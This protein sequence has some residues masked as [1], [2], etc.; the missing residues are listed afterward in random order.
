[1]STRALWSIPFEELLEAH[2]P[3]LRYAWA[4]A[5][6]AIAVALPIQWAQPSSLAT[7][8]VLAV[9]VLAVLPSWLWLTGRAVGLPIVPI[10]ALGELIIFAYP[11]WINSEAISYYSGEEILGACLAEIAFLGTMIIAWLAAQ[12]LP[13]RSTRI[14]ALR[15][16][17]FA[18]SGRQSTLFLTL[19]SSACFF[20]VAVA[21]GWA[22]DYFF[23]YVPNGV[24]TAFRPAATIAG[25]LGI[26]FLSMAHGRRQLSIPQRVIYLSIFLLYLAALGTSILLSAL[27]IQVLAWLAGYTLG[28]GRIPWVMVLVLPM[29]LNLLHVGKWEMRREHWDQFGGDADVIAPTEYPAFYADW[30][31]SGWEAI[32]KEEE[33]AEPEDSTSILDRASLVQMYLLAQNKAPADVPFLE[34]ETYAVIPKLMIPRI[35]WPDKPRTHLAQVILNVHFGRQTLEDTA[36]TY[37]AWGMLAESW[38]NFGIF[39]PPV[40]GLVLGGFLGWVAKLGYRVPMGSM[41]FLLSAVV[42]L[43]SINATQQVMSIWITT[44]FQALIPVIGACVLTMSPV[45]RPTP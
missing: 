8:G 16:D 20:S 38:S 37:I 10:V 42:L 34:G 29:V 35:L 36:R 45:A 2:R 11:V 17:G 28:R 22:W 3:M 27:A 23:Q 32:S 7:V 13:D 33:L 12:S 4:F 41:R 15:L 6:A 24:Y 26:F 19:L 14:L 25:L 30:F 1:M 18:D 21:A 39:G 44:L 40:L 9:V 43:L 31:R 5:I